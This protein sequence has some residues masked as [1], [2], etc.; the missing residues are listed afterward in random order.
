MTTK[1]WTV[2]ATETLLQNPWFAVLGRAVELPD[3][4][5]IDFQSVEFHRPAVGVIPRRGGEI[6]LIRQ[7][8]LTVDRFVWAIPSGG[9]DEG[10]TAE[11]AAR[12]ELLEEAALVAGTMRPLVVYHPSYGATNQTF[13]VFLA[14]GA[15][16][17]ATALDHN[18]VIETRWFAQ[19]EVLRMLLHN[20]IVD[21]LSATPLAML[22]LEEEL[23]RR[24]DELRLKGRID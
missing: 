11:S 20:E 19:A 2:L 3:G 24:G 23:A 5:Q 17:S 15:R 13:E 6:L 21:G 14:D 16:P 10:E 12:R 8:R 22:F 18:E 9:I 4:R 7:Y 1:P